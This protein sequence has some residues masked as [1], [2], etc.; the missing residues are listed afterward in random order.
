MY[1][2]TGVETR[3]CPLL[4]GSGGFL[5]APRLNEDLCVVLGRIE[6]LKSLRS[7]V[8]ADLPSDQRRHRTCSCDT[9]TQHGG[10]LLMK[11]QARKLSHKLRVIEISLEL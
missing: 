2:E 11:I 6:V 5:A 4:L 3:P 9:M 7:S 1:T 8:N 10:K